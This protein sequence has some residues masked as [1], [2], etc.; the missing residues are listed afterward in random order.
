MPY[1]V[2][3]YFWQ[4]IKLKYVKCA[5]FKSIAKTQH[6]LIKNSLMTNINYLKWQ[7]QEAMQAV[8][9]FRPL[10]LIGQSNRLKALSLSNKV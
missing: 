6:V 4:Y 2:S 10:T 7:K 1:V 3:I 9:K 8:I 5:Q